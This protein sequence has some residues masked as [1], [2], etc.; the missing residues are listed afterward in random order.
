MRANP[1]QVVI[2]ECRAGDDLET[3][4]SQSRHRQVALET[5]A[6]VG[7]LR[8]GNSAYR[9]IHLVIGDA[10]QEGQRA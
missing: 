9:R 3:I 7:H 4:A 1:G 5:A 10:L 8:I 6:L 2:A